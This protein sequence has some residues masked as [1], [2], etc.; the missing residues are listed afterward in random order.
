[1]PVLLYRSKSWILTD[2][3]I[4]KLEAFQGE[5]MKRILKW[6]KHLSD[7]AA[8]TVLDVPAM[9]YRLLVNK[10]GFLSW[11]IGKSS[12][13]L[14]GRVVLALCDDFNSLYLLKECK[15]LEE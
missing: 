12:P 1:M 5:S 9:R 2:G 4:K 14:S 10:L 6:P 13:C 15:E 7:N 3:L 11:L 8:V